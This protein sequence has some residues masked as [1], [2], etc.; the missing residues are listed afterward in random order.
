MLVILIFIVGS[1]I[2]HDDD[3]N[4]DFDSSVKPITHWNEDSKELNY[5]NEIPTD[6]KFNEKYDNITVEIYFYNNDSDYISKA[7]VTNKT[8]GNYLIINSTFK[9]NEKPSEFELNFIPGNLIEIDD[10]VENREHNMYLDISDF[11]NNLFSFI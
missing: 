11:Y 6:F 1:V 5:Y 4:D 9:L 2:F 8:V 7:S 3:F 10:A